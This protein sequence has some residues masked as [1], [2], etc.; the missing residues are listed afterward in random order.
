M[1]E[2][3]YSLQELHKIIKQSP[4]NPGGIKTEYS[5]FRSNM[6]RTLVQ[7]RGLANDGKD[8]GLS[9]G[10]ITESMIVANITMILVLMIFLYKS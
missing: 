1:P 10:W 5:T 7:K 3:C 8:D 2:Y 9:M 6:I 4:D